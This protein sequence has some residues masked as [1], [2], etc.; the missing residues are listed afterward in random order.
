MLYYILVSGEHVH[1]DV[2]TNNMYALQYNI[3]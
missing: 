3:N 2:L 1:M